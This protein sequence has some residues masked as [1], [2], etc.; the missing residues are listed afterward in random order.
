M[1]PND[2]RVVS[3][4]IVQALRNRPLTIY[5]DG[6][7]TRSFCYVAD[8]IDAFVKLMDT[9]DDFTGPVNLGN[10]TEFTILD[11]AELVIELTNSRSIIER[12]PLPADDPQQRKPDT[13]LAASKLAWRATTSLRDGLKLTIPYF[14]AL[15]SELELRSARKA[16]AAADAA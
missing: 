16:A 2:G 8:L 6:S 13:S 3:N 4:F 15:L 11:L 1:H 12:R 7:Q 5:G 10:A 9:P 14:D